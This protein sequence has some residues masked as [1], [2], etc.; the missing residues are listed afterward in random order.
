MRLL[1]TR[2]SPFAH[3]VHLALLEKGVACEYEYVQ[4]GDPALLA[5]NP[6][7]KVPTLVRDDG[8]PLYD[9]A[10]ILQWLERFGRPLFPAD[11]DARIDALQWEATC[12]GACD[13]IVAS[14]AERRRAAPDAGFITL[15]EGKARRALELLEATLGPSGRFDAVDIALV[16]TLMYVDLR[17]PALREGL[18][19]LDRRLAELVQRPSVATT[20]P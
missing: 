2:T 14:V 7:G 19:G 4:L 5:L 13:A 16:A 9:S 3:K 1:L 15:Q 8:R 12:D 11:P 6:L 17:A 18:F 20:R 10:V